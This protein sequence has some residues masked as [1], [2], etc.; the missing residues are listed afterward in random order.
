MT[1][2]QAHDSFHS[3]AA[4]SNLLTRLGIYAAVALVFVLLAATAE[5]SPSMPVPEAAYSGDS[6][7]NDNYAVIDFAP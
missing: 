6:Q 5:R 2:S 7:M 4:D 1:V 3:A